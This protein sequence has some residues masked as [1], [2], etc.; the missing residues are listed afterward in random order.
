M[1]AR[2]RDIVSYI[3]DRLRKAGIEFPELEAEIITANLCDISR[4]QLLARDE[5]T[6]EPKTLDSVLRT[7]AG[8][9]PLQYLIGYADFF[10]LRFQVTPETLIP[11]PSTETLVEKAIEIIGDKPMLLLDVGTGCGNIAISILANCKN[12]RAVLSDISFEALKVAKENSKMHD[13]YDRA[14]FVKANMLQGFKRSFELILSN[15]PYIKS[16][17]LSSLQPE[18]RHEPPAA[19]DGGTDGLKYVNILLN[20]TCYLKQDGHILIEK[21]Y[22][23]HLTGLRMLP[24]LADVERVIWI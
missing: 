10:S 24:D 8:R 3:D 2:A 22:D 15:P 17:D 1:K 4:E 18:V 23:Q 11:R 5:I 16:S 21:G 12:C 6:I 13:V 7:R 9:Y 14:M 19:L 20:S